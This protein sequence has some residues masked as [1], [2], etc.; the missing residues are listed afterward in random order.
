M[1]QFG[2]TPEKI[3]DAAELAQVQ[4]QAQWVLRKSALAAIP[5]TLIGLVLPG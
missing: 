2:E 3:E 5:L 4:R 1:R